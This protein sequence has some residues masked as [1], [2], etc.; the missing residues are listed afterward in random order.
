M[1][2]TEGIPPT[3]DHDGD[4]VRTEEYVPSA[5]GPDTVIAGHYKLVEKLGDG[6]MG[7]VWIA[8]Q[9]EPV[10]RTVALKVIKAGMDTRGCWLALS[11]SGKPSQL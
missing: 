8:K 7:E 5:I 9:T 4:P 2:P 6:G 3:V 11:R 1:S 10:R